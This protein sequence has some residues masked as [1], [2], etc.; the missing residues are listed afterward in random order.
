MFDKYIKQLE[1]ED[2]EMRRRAINALGN[3]GNPV[4]L[5]ALGQIYKNDPE[6]HLRQL[7]REAGLRIRDAMNNPTK[8]VEDAPVMPSP[9]SAPVESAPSVEQPVSELEHI[10]EPD[11]DLVTTP[12]APSGGI[13]PLSDAKKVQDEVASSAANAARLKALSQKTATT[14]RKLPIPDKAKK[15]NVS[16][17]NVKRAK[18]YMEGAMTAE[19][20]Q[21]N[22]RAMKLMANALSIN[23]N[24]VKD[25]FFLGVASQVTGEGGDEALRMIVDSQQRKEF[26]NAASKEVV[27]RR[28]DKHMES[29]ETSTTGASLFEVILFSLIVIVGSALIGLVLIETANAFLET[30]QSQQGSAEGMVEITEGL[31]SLR[32]A[33]NT[34]MLI[35]VI[36]SALSGVVNLFVT[37]FLTHLIARYVLRGHGTYRH[38]LTKL[39]SFYNRML[40]FW[41]LFT[42]IL[43][44]IAFVSAGSVVI[45]CLSL[46]FFF[47]TLFIIFK[48][49]GIIGQ[50]YDI[51]TA[52]G[53]VSFLLGSIASSIVFGLISYLVTAPFIAALELGSLPTF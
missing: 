27:Q 28:I 10:E 49:S 16:E 42:Y 4:A 40:P 21:D 46:P 2:P 37:L 20:A 48:T 26:V 51:G 36:V 45:L 30:V 53:Y 13:R 44:A 35:S 7:A 43:I 31:A 34:I 47:F 22:A 24:L 50:A 39:L 33:I 11:I 23:P 6:P 32:S 29:V 25:P 19:L 52:R 9:V 38:L 3:L 5:K 18:E 8:P 12:P 15:Y 41:F 17:E 1:D 14:P